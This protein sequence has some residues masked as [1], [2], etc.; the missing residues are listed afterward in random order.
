VATSRVR[1]EGG[2]LLCPACGEDNL[3]HTGTVFFGRAQEDESTWAIEVDA[4]GAVPLPAARAALFN[5]SPRRGAVTV[6]FMCEGCPAI[7]E[8]TFW[9]HK[10]QT[11]IGWRP[12]DATRD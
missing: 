8:L 1:I 3:H 7:S 12:A 2:V 5:P 4:G 11:Q 10:G 6:R 9:Q